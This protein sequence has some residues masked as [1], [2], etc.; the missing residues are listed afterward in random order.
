M[1]LEIGCRVVAGLLIGLTAFGVAALGALQLGVDVPAVALPLMIAL[2]LAGALG[3]HKRGSFAAPPKGPGAPTVIILSL[4]VLSIA[5]VTMVAYGA[6]ATP[7]RHWDGAVAWDVKAHYLADAP[8]LDQP[9]FR[10][11]Y[12]LVHSRGYPLLQP[13]VMAA[14]DRLLGPGGG[15]VLFPVL[16]AGLLLL[17]GVGLRR[18]GVAGTVAWLSAAGCVLAPRLANP[19]SGG[20]DSGYADLFLLVATT[21]LAVGLLG[22]DV[23]FLATGAALAVM[24]KPEGMIYAGLAI[25]VAWCAGE[26]RQTKWVT[27]GWVA[28][29]VAWLPVQGQL[30]RLDDEG[31]LG[32]R[33]LP[34]GVGA[35]VLGADRVARNLRLE[36]RGRTMAIALFLAVLTAALPW[37]A[38]VANPGLLGTLSEYLEDPGRAVRRL[39]SVPAIMVGAIG[40]AMPPGSFALAFAAPLVAGSALLLQRR[41][42][43]A[44][45]VAAFVAVG[46][47]AVLG[48]F[49][50]SPEEDL[51]H[52][53]RS[54]MSRLLLH[55]VGPAMLLAGVWS[56]ALWRPVGD[57]P[58][59]RGEGAP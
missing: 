26:R 2:G 9:Y 7:S 55:W 36:V 49:V 47:T 50:L 8:T 30:Q 45:V 28:G 41:R 34:L 56:D 6:L 13:L 4:G 40:Y 42:P 57:R 52:H 19:T 32:L 11:R 16:Y 35:A 20:A 54:S 5:A 10:D 17:I 29:A 59:A 58:Q 25:A 21:A 51:D 43:A 15:R 38:G 24:V 18:A 27:L 33:L 22:K 23:R 1:S 44:G 46:I 48:A 31:T 53:L 39:Q 14:G 3:L 12:V 37:L